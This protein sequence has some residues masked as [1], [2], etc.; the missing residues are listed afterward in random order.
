[1][2]EQI[3]AK[4][5]KEVKYLAESVDLLIESVK[6]AE[7]HFLYEDRNVQK[8]IKFQ[9]LEKT[10]KRIRELMFVNV[11]LLNLR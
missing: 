5:S 9:D 6:L 8:V 11:N 10:L 4:L 1:M 2:S 7:N 3:E